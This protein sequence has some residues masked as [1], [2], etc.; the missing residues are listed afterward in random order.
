[1]K[2]FNQ[3]GYKVLDIEVDDN[4]YRHRVIMGEHSLTLYYSLPEHVELPV[5]SY[6]EF[7]G[8][9]FTLERPEAFKMKHSRYF[10]YTVTMEAPE[11]KAKIW[12]FRNTV[13]GRLKFSLTA[14]PVEH[15]QMFVDNM[16]RR[17]KGWTVG[18][19]IDGVEQCINYDHAF[20][21]DALKQQASEFK[22]EYEFK[23]KRVSLKKVEYNKTYP[24]PLSYGRGNGF[25]SGVGRTNTGEQPPVEILYVQGGTDNL[26][27]S[28]YGASEL[29]LPKSQQLG[30]DGEHFDT[31][32]GFNQDS[33]RLY[34]TDEDGLSIRRYD[35]QLASLAEDSLDCSSIS[36][37]RVGEVSKVI[38]VDAETNFYD[39]TDTTIPETL[40]F[41]ECLIEGETMTVI[42]QTGMLA[43][44]E[45][46]VKYYHEAKT[47]RGVKKEA[48]RFELVPQEIDGQTMPNETFKPREGDKYAVF[49][50]MMPDAYICDN[51]TKTGASWDMFREAVKYLFDNEDTKLTFTGE[52]DGIWAKKDW[53]NIGGRIVLGGFI[54]FTDPRFQPDPVLV[55][56]TGIKDYI[57]KPYSPVIE[58]SNTTVSGGVSSTL[59][60]LQSQEVLIE[61]NQR[62]ALQFTKRRF[63][64]ARETIAMLEAS[65]LDNFTGSISPIAVQTMS[66][67][68]GDESLQFRFVSSRTNPVQV[69]HAITWDNEQKQ[70]TAEAG[71]IQHMTLGISSLSSSHDT[72]EY[73]F[74][75]VEEYMSGRIEEGEKKFYLYAKVSETGQTGSFLL[76]ETAI[77]MG[78]VSGFYHLLVGVLNS[79]YDGERSFVTL[80][81]FT[82]VL[83]G[84]VTTDRVVSGDG[85]SYFDM[86]A[87]ALKLGN[88]LSF[89][90]QGDGL[91]RLRGTL[92]QN[93]G[94]DESYIGCYRG[95][96]NAAYVYYNG[97]EVTFTANGL[98][99]TYRYVYATPSRGVVPT[100][101]TYWQILAEGQKG[102][103]GDK[104]DDG[105]DGIDGLSPNTAYKSTVFKR[106]NTA[107]TTPTG[108]S[109]ANP[110]PTGWSDGVPSGEEK[111]WA[112]T[113]I[114]SSDGL[115]PQQAS[116]TTPRQMTDTADFDVEFSSVDNPSAPTGH[117]NTNSQWTNTA[118][119]AT[120]WMAT[121]VKNNGVWGAWQISRIKGEKGEDGTSIKIK[122]TVSSVSDLPTPPADSSDCYIVGQNL[123]VWDGDSW[124]NA[125]QF[126]GDKGDSGADGLDG[127]NA[128]VHI[129]YAKSLTEGDWSD[130]NGETPDKYIGI[131]CDSLPTDSMTWSKYSW[132][133]WKGDDGFGYEYIYKRTTNQI[134][135]STPTTTSQ[136]DDYV[137]SGWTDNPSGVS[138]DYP[139]E[140]VCYRK[141]VDGVWGAFKGSASD[142]TQASLWAR[143]ALPTNINLLEGT[144]FQNEEFKRFWDVVDSCSVKSGVTVNDYKGN[145]LTGTSGYQGRNAFRVGTKYS[146]NSI[147]YKE[148][149]RQPIRKKLK[150]STWYTLS[151]WQRCSADSFMY[152]D[153]TGSG[154]PFKRYEL[155]LRSGQKYRCSVTGFVSSA[156]YLAGLS[157]SVFIY[158]SDWSWS[159]SVH[160]KSMAETT[161]TI[162]F[163]NV[164]ADGTY[165]IGVYAYPNTETREDVTIRRLYLYNLNAHAAAYIFPS[166]IDTSYAG[167]VD[168]VSKTLNSD[169][170]TYHGHGYWAFHSF[171]FRT[172]ATIPTAEQ[173]VL[174]RLLPALTEA[175]NI[176]HT[177]I[178][179]PKLEEGKEATPYTEHDNDGHAPYY[180]LR[181]A[182]NAST[183]V[184]PS[185]DITALEP[186]GWSTIQPSVSAFEYLWMTTAKKN[187]DGSLLETWSTPV[188]VT[189]YDGKDGRDGVNGSSPVMVYRGVY[190]SSKTYYGNANRLDCVKSGDTYYIARIDAGTFSNVAPPNTNKWNSFGASFESVATNLLLAEN[191]NIGDW[192]MSG[193]KIV[194]TLS[195]GDI[196]ELDAKN[197]RIYIKSATSGGD[198]AVETGLGSQIELNAATGIIEARSNGSTSA[199]SYMSPSGIFANRA[200]TRCVAASSG[201]DQRAAICGLGYGNLNKT[202]WDTGESTLLAAVYGYASNSGTA[203]AFGGYFFNLK[204]NGLTLGIK[205]IFG[206][207]TSTTYLT[208]AQTLVVG[209]S[210]VKQNVYLPASDKQGQ[211]IILKQLWTGYMR[212]YPRSGYKLFDDSTENEYYDVG[213]GQ[214]LIAHFVKF[215]IN[216]E[217]VS[218]WT[219][220]R[221]KY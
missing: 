205:K 107:P 164:P 121:A 201:L 81:G 152:E 19:C 93:E 79:E 128:Y 20:C 76:S 39:F 113:R 161:A 48:R 42:F 9:T 194:S 172:K 214:C 94:G 49:N 136:N 111:L 17:D 73:R 196:I 154:Y 92:V 204:A 117:P 151:Y 102:D 145:I 15:L 180:E 149:L 68:V 115:D 216:G 75:D 23:G 22:T 91:L 104:G 189:P 98:T 10:E 64:D 63:R 112:S 37:K 130:N 74:W 105:A 34:I 155:C 218:V 212:V 198:Y 24:L 177:D 61:D 36:P 179:M 126:K 41:E 211:T 2:I 67:L 193:G 4:S 138:A 78:Q 167:I 174:F 97:D 47:V 181:Y 176:Y 35:K 21:L 118:S 199:V 56:I 191:A 28:K 59:K 101:P 178:C 188:R 148:V 30:F 207:S 119:K 187:F 120:I 132:S 43:G 85:Q 46:E 166:I 14:K 18:D 29:R 96:W 51:K 137:P 3:L 114:F 32:D 170:A 106:S 44:R 54:R 213:Q 27:P 131:Y 103:K 53:L 143:Y 95:V 135:P 157:L 89:N 100:N 192:F 45:F 38:T 203:P 13:D 134:A 158:N 87:N 127:V 175:G 184:P 123:Y 52:L 195:S 110:V 70:L 208:D 144:G 169:G 80:Y 173:Y 77:K 160:I 156:A 109:Y 60:E 200:G 209:L 219:L 168:G 165:Y 7:Q 108:G 62:A 140:W 16:N 182:K 183:S 26:D 133:K 5:G 185:L 72:S 159:K 215:S 197:N 25:K 40:N 55:R 69:A 86:I 171:T 162:D 124:V 57:N 142:P 202:E 153:I 1:M 122:G 12:K 147:N 116:W 31:E 8:E 58:L 220:S 186:S 84:R 129:K 88:K 217:N 65:L 150:P 82:E 50:C 190:D 139:Y 90:T 221:F 206:T 210:S 163:D 66:L 6:C 71:I 146:L 141:K 33:S 99:S 11:A 83:P 125:G